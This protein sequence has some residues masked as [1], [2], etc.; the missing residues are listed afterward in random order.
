MESTVVEDQPVVIL[1]SR[2][3]VMMAHYPFI[4]SPG[5]RHLTILFSALHNTVND[6]IPREF[7][8]STVGPEVIVVAG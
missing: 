5:A 4:A 7:S 8:Q 2:D 1:L 6:L 3:W